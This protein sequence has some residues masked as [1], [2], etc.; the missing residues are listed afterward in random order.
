MARNPRLQRRH[1]GI[2]IASRLE[3]LDLAQRRELR[4]VIAG[5]ENAEARV[6]A[7]R[8]EVAEAERRRDAA[9]R[10]RDAAVA[11]ANRRLAELHVT[12]YTAGG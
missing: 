11:E 1:P 3:Q 6:D 5:R 12:N 7:A 4:S 8:A 9:E 10:R 2:D